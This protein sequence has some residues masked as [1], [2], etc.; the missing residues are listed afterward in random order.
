MD[1]FQ[2]TDAGYEALLAD[3]TALAPG[4][5]GTLDQAKL[6]LYV[7]NVDPGR[8]AD[9]SDFTLA[10]FTGSAPKTITA[11]G[12][13]ARDAQGDS[14]QAGGL[15][16]WNWTALG[17]ET[18]YGYVL[19]DAADNLLG[20]CKR[21]TPKVMGSASDSIIAVPVIGLGEDGFGGVQSIL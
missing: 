20:Y 6:K 2:L 7:N 11:W 9:I 19:T 15:L 14:E 17:P 8:T 21:S 5:A 18:V 13:V 1:P 4:G 12:E 3:M 16:Q 10:S